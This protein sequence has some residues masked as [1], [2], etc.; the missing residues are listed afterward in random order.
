MSIFL[1]NNKA[2]LS[3]KLVD[4]GSRNDG[5]IEGTKW[6]LASCP[7]ILEAQY[8]FEIEHMK[9]KRR[10]SSNKTSHRIAIRDS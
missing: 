8:I 1:F 4:T 3:A 10:V 2:V 7:R 6:A 9:P 5:I